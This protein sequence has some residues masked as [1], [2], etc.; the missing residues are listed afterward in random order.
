MEA[1]GRKDI[2]SLTLDEVKDEMSGLMEKPFRAV[3]LKK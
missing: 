3:Q 1:E 2:K